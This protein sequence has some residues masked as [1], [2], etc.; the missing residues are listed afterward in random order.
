MIAA[1]VGAKERLDYV[2]ELVKKLPDEP[3]IQSHWARYL[4]VLVSGFMETSL[5]QMYGHY[6]RTKAAPNVANY[7]EEQLRYFQ[8]PSMNKI[9]ELARSFSADWETELRVQT[10]G[11]RKD[12]VDSV[13]ANRHKIAHGEHVGITYVRVKEYYRSVV[14]V[15]GVIDQQCTK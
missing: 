11:Q 1:V 14:E 12:A 3:E 5:R 10:E 4:C 7:I 9:L 6:A 15:I 8:N 13:V 2:F